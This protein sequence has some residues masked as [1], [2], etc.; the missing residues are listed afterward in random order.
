[1]AISDRTKVGLIF[2]A[3]S[4][5]LIG[6]GILLMELG[7]GEW[8]EPECEG[9]WN[10]FNDCGY[11][12]TESEK[13]VQ[14]IGCGFG[15]AGICGLLVAAKVLLSEG[16]RQLFGKKS[17]NQGE[18]DFVPASTSAPVIE[19]EFAELDKELGSLE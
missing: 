13:S 6:L 9:G 7:E 16:F 11:E 15:S 5:V 3:I 2:T 18:I 10:F 1:M 8:D 14:D 17:N 12:Q 19:D 4:I